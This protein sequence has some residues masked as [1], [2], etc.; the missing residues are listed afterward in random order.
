MKKES[1][2]DGIFFISQKIFVIFRADMRKKTYF[3]NK[4]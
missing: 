2:H 4:I 1:R 3:C